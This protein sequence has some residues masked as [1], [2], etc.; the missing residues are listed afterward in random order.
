MQPHP[1]PPALREVIAHVHLQHRAD[2]GEGVDH[3][4]DQGPV[5]QPHQRLLQ[6]RLSL[7]RLVRRQERVRAGRRDGL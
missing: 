1:S 6:G 3:G 7:F 4:G 2:A 5:P